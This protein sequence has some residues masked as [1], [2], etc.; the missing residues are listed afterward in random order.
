MGSRVWRCVVHSW[1][2]YDLLIVLGRA[3]DRGTIRPGSGYVS[4]LRDVL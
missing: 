2:D 4:Q 1:C 3:N